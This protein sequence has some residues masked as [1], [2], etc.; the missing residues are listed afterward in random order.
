MLA[1]VVEREQLADQRESDAGFGRHVGAFELQALIGAIT[2]FVETLILGLEIEQCPRR[3]GHDQ[4]V[5]KIYAH[6][7]ILT[8]NRPKSRDRNRA[9]SGKSVSV[10]VNL[11]GPR[12]NK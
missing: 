8:P 10:R 2:L 6:A 4:L 12:I 1:I 9:G 3:Q 7:A 11:G 5:I